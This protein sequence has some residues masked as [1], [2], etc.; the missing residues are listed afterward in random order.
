MEKKGGGG[1]T[2]EIVKARL[3]Y[4]SVS[5]FLYGRQLLRINQV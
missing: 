4:F 5:L 3:D 1:G 2:A